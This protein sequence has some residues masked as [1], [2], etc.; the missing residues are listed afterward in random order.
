MSSCCM[1]TSSLI[2]GG[3][4]LGSKVKYHVSQGYSLERQMVPCFIVKRESPHR[5]HLSR[6]VCVRASE[7]G[8]QLRS[9]PVNSVGMVAAMALPD[10]SPS[11]AV[12][13][14][15]PQADR[16][17]T[18]GR[19]VAGIDQADLRD[20][21][22]VADKD[23]QF[24]LFRG[25]E[26]H[27][28]QAEPLPPPPAPVAGTPPE[29]ALPE[30]GKAS[31]GASP[32]LPPLML[33][34]P[35]VL[36]HGFG[37][38]LFSWERV[39]RPL[40]SLLGA[41]AL[42]F[43]RPA[44]GLTAKVKPSRGRTGKRGN[45]E[46][47]YSTAFSAAATLAF[48][49]HLQPSPSPAGA[50]A[51]AT[52]AEPK[53]AILVAHSAGSL[54][55]AQAFLDCPEKVAALIL[56]APAI[57]APLLPR[58]NKLP[59]TAREPYAAQQRVESEKFK[60]TLQKSEKLANSSGKQGGG[61]GA[62][63]AAEV[64]VA[65]GAGGAGGAEGTGGGAA[66]AVAVGG[67][68]AAPEAGASRG[69][70]DAEKQPV[71]KPIARTLVGSIPLPPQ[72]VIS[73]LLTLESMLASLVALATARAGQAFLRAGMALGGAGR[74]V[75]GA[76]SAAA[77]RARA[78]VSHA[79][80]LR[81]LLEAVLLAGRFLRAACLW[82]FA[83]ACLFL[84]WVAADV[85]RAAALILRAAERAKNAVVA[86]A[87]RSPLALWGV[88]NAMNRSGIWAVRNAWHNPALVD[89]YVIGGYTKP[90]RVRHW[91]RALIEFG[92]AAGGNPPL[93][94]RLHQ[95]TC[96]VLVVTGDDDRLV[97]AWNARRLAAALPRAVFRVIEKCGH[98]PQEEKPEELLAIVREF[99]E[100]ELKGK[101][102]AAA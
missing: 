55:A 86:G 69:A 81:Q 67:A 20:P 34:N 58:D 101:Q 1:C 24:A 82:V 61:E 9:S 52:S 32:P 27:F 14:T 99:L 72:P 92:L 94:N 26:I 79:P 71:R 19:S 51:G 97:P 98:C 7:E 96:P 76:A 49:D 3:S 95:I 56:V 62:A 54:V 22:Q 74:N 25:V 90:L 11:S 50:G 44:F 78:S 63:G 41:P 12:S 80:V 70:L 75:S 28:K 29:A 88:R 66:A 100:A 57:R 73:I 30:E 93:S 35:A 15:W 17:W 23:S 21:R 31:S 84:L 89:D 68:A 87:M 64:A 85:R 48:V 16:R 18:K 45:A 38:S 37:A 13:S 47:P 40:A 77:G 33:G 59:S 65:G 60:A 83:K 46:N 102:P 91:D 8:Q 2:L 4:F 43:D 5:R 10:V 39:L 42:A 36:L 6:G 53:P